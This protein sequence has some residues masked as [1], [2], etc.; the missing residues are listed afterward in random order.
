MKCELILTP[1]SGLNQ[2]AFHD[3]KKK[4]KILY[5]YT[6]THTH[7]HTHTYTHTLFGWI[8][9]SNIISEK[10]SENKTTQDPALNTVHIQSTVVLC[11]MVT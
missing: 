6:H 5:I 4:K 7:T 11:S 2:N 10:Y 8:N 1:P 9:L 3:K